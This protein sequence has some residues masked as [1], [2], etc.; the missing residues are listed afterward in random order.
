MKEKSREPGI[1]QQ[2]PHKKEDDK[3][4][5]AEVQDAPEDDNNYKDNKISQ[6]ILDAC[7]CKIRMK[8]VT[9]P[10]GA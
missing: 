2:Q 3:Q 5:H 1:T 8:K 6:S 4:Q 9:Y 10:S 7:I